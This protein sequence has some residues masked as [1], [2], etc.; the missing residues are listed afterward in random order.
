[1]KSYLSY[2]KLKFI[3]GLQYRAAAFAGISTQIF[4]GIM[5]IS[6]YVAFYESDT[7]SIPMP[8]N[9]L[10]SYLW[11]NQCFFALIY[12]WYKDK[13][14]INLIKNGNIAYELCRPQ[15]LYLMW[16]S[17]MYG[18]RLSKVLLR[19]LPVIIFA[20]ILPSPFNL[21]LSTTLP[22]FILFTVSLLLAS[23][24]VT[25]IVLLY[26]IIC[27]FTLDEKG[28]VNM[29][30][31]VSDILSGLTIPIPFFPSYLQK[32]SDILPFRYVSDFPFR[33]Y[34]GNIS[35]NEGFVGIVMQLIWIVILII[36]GNL[37][38]KKALKKAVV[39]GG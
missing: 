13:E 32:I 1:M 12:M 3:T 10:V 6:V 7:S 24:L 36:I 35:I 38:M 33:L 8:L 14:I 19:F 39:Q 4:F 29:F 18:D 20:L 5:Y 25:A 21:D 30:M 34:I 27:L 26:H 16:F 11:L 15:N 28:I 22:R 31:V 23:V 2:F 17:K 9:Q 37:L